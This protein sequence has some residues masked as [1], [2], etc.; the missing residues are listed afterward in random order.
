MNVRWDEFPQRSRSSTRA[1]IDTGAT[2]NAVGIACLEEMVSSG[3]FVHEVSH[4]SLPV[5][6]SQCSDLAMDTGAEH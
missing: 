6:G 4:D 1:V 5:T 3:H 2:E